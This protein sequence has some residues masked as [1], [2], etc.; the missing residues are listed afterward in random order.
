MHLYIEIAGKTC[1]AANACQRFI[2]QLSQ[3]IDAVS[4]A[5]VPPLGPLQRLWLWFRRKLGIRD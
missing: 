3:L 2:A 4:A 1:E 5:N